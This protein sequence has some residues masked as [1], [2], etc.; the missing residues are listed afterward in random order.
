MHGTLQTS[1]KYENITQ[2]V[3]WSHLQFAVCSS[4]LNGRKGLQQYVGD[5]QEFF[6]AT[7][8]NIIGQPYI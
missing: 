8:N 7:N 5:L 2:V 4:S 3:F 1:L 6:L